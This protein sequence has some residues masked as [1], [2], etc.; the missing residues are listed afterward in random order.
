MTDWIKRKWWIPVGALGGF[1]YAA[2]ASGAL[3]AEVSGNPSAYA[4][5]PPGALLL[6]VGIA[7]VIHKAVVEPRIKSDV[8]EPPSARAESD[9]TRATEERAKA[10]GLSAAEL[11]AYRVHKA[12]EG[13]TEAQLRGDNGM[14]R[15][16]IAFIGLAAVE[17]GWG[18]LE[19][20]ARTLLASSWG[21]GNGRSA[22]AEF[23]RFRASV[24]SVAKPD[25]EYPDSL[26]DI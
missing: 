25:G 14:A 4:G 6:G 26:A 13:L 12:F 16:L 20:S 1:L 23:D 11:W 17:A 22:S 15:K 18:N 3:E 10:M 8:Q 2:I 7:W 5:P 24:L 19:E 21:T 9:L